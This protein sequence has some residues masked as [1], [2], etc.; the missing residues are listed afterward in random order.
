MFKL[1]V[2]AT[3]GIAAVTFALTAVGAAPASAAGVASNTVTQHLE[4]F[5]AYGTSPGCHVRRIYLA[6]GDYRWSQKMGGYTNPTR[7]IYLAAGNY[8]WKDCLWVPAD[9][10]YDQES[11]LFQVGKSSGAHLDDHSGFNL[12]GGSGTYTWG[13]TLQPLFDV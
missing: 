4:A 8:D 11:S 3:L 6:A 9:T 13:S 2:I 5:P 1:K 7:I 10:A 12:S